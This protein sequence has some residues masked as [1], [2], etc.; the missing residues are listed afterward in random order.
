MNSIHTGQ[1]SQAVRKK[2]DE[3]E[4]NNMWMFMYRDQIE[5]KD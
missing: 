2:L 5:K 1:Q 4:K 3:L